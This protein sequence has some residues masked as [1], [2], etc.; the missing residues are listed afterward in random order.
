M[1]GKK[2]IPQS[3]TT[4]DADVMFLREQCK[5]NKIINFINVD[6]SVFNHKTHDNSL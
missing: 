1:F 5:R 3:C 2:A 4:C 6:F